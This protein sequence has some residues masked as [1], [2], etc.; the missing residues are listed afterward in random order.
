LR[1]RVLL[2]GATK[3]IAYFTCVCLL[4]SSCAATAPTAVTTHLQASQT[5]REHDEKVTPNLITDYYP[6]QNHPE[7]VIYRLKSGGTAD[8][9]CVPHSG[10]SEM[11]IKA[12]G[13][14]KLPDG[15]PLPAS[16]F[17]LL[18]T[19]DPRIAMVRDAENTKILGY[20]ARNH[21]GTVRLFPDLEKAQ[22]FEHQGDAARTAGK[23]VVGALLIT[24]VLG[25]VVL[26][27][28]AGASAASSN[29]ITTTCNSVGYGFSS[30]TTCTTH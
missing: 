16:T 19:D 20:I 22:A 28:A 8:A 14:E 2:T 7:E 13:L 15:T 26:G 17:R 25:L 10:C 11:I 12:Q 3:G 23:I 4:L 6:D 30:S 21:D 5:E 18:K 29:Q 1:I 9:A 27:A 24:A